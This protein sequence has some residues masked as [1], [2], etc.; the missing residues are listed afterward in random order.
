MIAVANMGVLRF[1]Q[2]DTH[3]RDDTSISGK[4]SSVNLS[5]RAFS[6]LI[7]VKFC[8]DLRGKNAT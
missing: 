2:N 4:E 6:A 3:F 1:A 7:R 5:I 8:T